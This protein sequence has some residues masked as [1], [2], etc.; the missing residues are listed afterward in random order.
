MLVISL[1]LVF[2][3]TKIIDNRLTRFIRYMGR[4]CLY[5]YIL[6][7][8]FVFSIYSIGDIY[9]AYAQSNNIVQHT[10]GILIQFVTSFLLSLITLA[11]S[12]TIMIFIKR[13]ALFDMLLFGNLKRYTELLPSIHLKKSVNEETMRDDNMTTEGH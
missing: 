6:H 12:L 1:F 8:F 5:I 10:T 4:N 2:Q 11:V 7:P 3:N 13:L 9:V